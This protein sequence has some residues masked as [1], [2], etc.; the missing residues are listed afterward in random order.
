MIDNL[1]KYIVIRFILVWL[2]DNCGW[3]LR[4][5]SAASYK[6]KV[7]FL[8]SDCLLWLEEYETTEK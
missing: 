2:V 5:T 8:F 1:F 7:D 4:N 6:E 3:I